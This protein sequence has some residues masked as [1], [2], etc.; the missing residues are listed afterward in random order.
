MHDALEEHFRFALQRLPQVVV[1][2]REH[3][4]VRT[5]ALQVAQIQPLAG[6][7]RAQRAGAFVGEHPLHL[8]I[9]HGGRVQL[10]GD[11]Q[12]QQLIVRDAAPDEERQ[13]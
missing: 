7:V 12:V 2:I 6:E 8:L 9:E 3:V 11:G 13:A 1:E 4:L 5:Q 10:A